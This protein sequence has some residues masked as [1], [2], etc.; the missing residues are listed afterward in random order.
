MNGL[1]TER[2]WRKQYFKKQK[3]PDWW[4]AQYVFDHQRSHPLCRDR[5]FHLFLLLLSILFSVMLPWFVPRRP[6]FQVTEALAPENM[7]VLRPRQVSTIHYEPYTAQTLQTQICTVSELSGGRLLLLDATHPF[8]KDLPPPNTF[9]IASYGHGMIPVSSLQIQSG[10]ETIAA[11]EKLFRALREKGVHNLQVCSGTVSKAQQR[12]QLLL[13]LRNRMKTAC[14]DEAVADVISRLEWPGTGEMLGEHSVEMRFHSSPSE[15]EGQCAV[16]SS[17][18][19]ILFQTAWRYGFIC[20]HQEEEDGEVYR[21]R[22]VGIAHAT[23]MTFLNLDLQT[24]LHF[25]H[26]KGSLTIW[27]NNEPKYLIKCTPVTGNRVQFELP[28][29][30][31]WEASL[32]NLGYAVAVCTL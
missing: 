31:S 7:E 21:F 24:Y 5:A 2:E 27:E 18:E 29:D 6:A 25:L 12:K 17:A 16:P 30:V 19:P 26:Q 9:S 13:T 11:L 1:M 14:V 23:A 20:T 8:P 10:K 28:A 4:G 32:D 3:R 22:Y 15:V